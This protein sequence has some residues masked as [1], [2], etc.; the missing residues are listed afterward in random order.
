MT[1]EIRKN[2]ASRHFLLLALLAL[3]ALSA[4]VFAGC[5]DSPKQPPRVED[6]STA[7][8]KR[9]TEARREAG[10]AESGTNDTSRE[11]STPVDV[12]AGKDTRAE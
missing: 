1:V 3:F 11:T 9:N 4:A 12:G 8:D 2:L 10:P 5:G 6:L 7:K